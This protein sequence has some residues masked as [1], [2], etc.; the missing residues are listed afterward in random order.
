MT[1]NVSRAEPMAMPWSNDPYFFEPA[2]LEKLLGKDIVEF[3]EKNPPPL[4]SAPGKCRAREVL[5]R[6]AGTKRPLPGLR[7]SR[8]SSWASPSG[9]GRWRPE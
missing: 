5:L 9:P 7:S 6:H 8:A 2:E 1:T 3:M 4:P